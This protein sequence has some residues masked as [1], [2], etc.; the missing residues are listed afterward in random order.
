MATSLMLA[1]T[2]TA[3]SDSVDP[4]PFADAPDALPRPPS[5]DAFP[6][7]LA[8]PDRPDDLPLPQERAAIQARLQDDRD[9][10]LIRLTT[11]TSRAVIE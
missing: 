3:C 7:L 11:G 6:S 8:I 4:R 2:L 1:A 9:A 5:S 10:A